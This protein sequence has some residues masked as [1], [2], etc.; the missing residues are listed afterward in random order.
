MIL[1]KPGAHRDAPRIQPNLRLVIV[2]K[3]IYQ[4]ARGKA[5]QS[6]AE[7]KQIRQS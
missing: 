7:L 1:S 3:T 4:E 6:I 5:G 2:K